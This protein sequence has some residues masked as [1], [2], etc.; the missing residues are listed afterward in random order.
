MRIA[1]LIC[2]LVLLAGA[3]FYCLDTA[4]AQGTDEQ[5]QACAPDAMR[6]CSEFI[7]DVGKVTVCMQKKSAQ[8]SEACRVAMRGG[9]K[10]RG[11]AHERT[12]RERHYRSRS[13]HSHCDPQSHM[14]S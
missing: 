9:G 13:T 7:P 5:R 14:C 10:S 6:L 12:H 4:N 2:W 3:L 1:S 11:E 8:L